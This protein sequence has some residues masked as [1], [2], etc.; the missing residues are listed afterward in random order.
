[1]R[2]LIAN[3]AVYDNYIS[4][5]TSTENYTSQP[6]ASKKSHN[7]YIHVSLLSC[8]CHN[9]IFCFARLIMAGFHLEN[10][11]GGGAA[12]IYNQF[13][14]NFLLSIVPSFQSFIY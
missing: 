3:H 7:L 6:R 14:L 5:K 13:L 1:M 12:L 9:N 2:I 11:L 8:F 10:L 4:A